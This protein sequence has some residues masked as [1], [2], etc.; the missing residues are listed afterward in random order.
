[1]ALVCLTI[2]YT[3]VTPQRWKKELM[4]GMPKDKDSS[5]VVA[6]RLFP[7]FATE[8]KLKKHHGRADAL[9]I[10]EYLRRKEQGSNETS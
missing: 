4:D 3:L 5:R 10:A 1:M 8:L 6:I 7:T 9:L 2:P